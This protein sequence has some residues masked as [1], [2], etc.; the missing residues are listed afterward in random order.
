MRIRALSDGPGR[1]VPGV[2]IAGLDASAPLG[3]E[4]RGALR[5]VFFDNHLVLLRGQRLDI[6]EQRRFVETFGTVRVPSWEIHPHLAD[7]DLEHT[8]ISNTRADGT[9]GGNAE[10][11]LHQDYSFEEP[12][13]G[14]ALYAIEVPAEGGETGFA[15]TAAALERLTPALRERIANLSATHFERFARTATPNRV[16]HP[17]VLIHPV[18]KRPALF[19]D[20]LFTESIDGVTPEASA[21]LLAEVWPVFDDPSLQYWH[22]W[23]PGDLIVWDNLVLQHARRWFAPEQTR[24]LRRFQIDFSILWSQTS[25]EVRSCSLRLAARPLTDSPSSFST[26]RDALVGFTRANVARLGTTMGPYRSHGLRGRS[27][28]RRTCI[29]SCVAQRSSTA[30]EHRAVRPMSR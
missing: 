8:Y 13:G 3:D 21:E 6:D 20:P 18:T 14:I 25:E 16:S 1:G 29:R 17:V 11:V 4:D 5:E 26:M 9:G 22:R 12:V 27:R 23:E 10:L 28:G 15:N 2:E 7:T 19:A 30:P 24:T